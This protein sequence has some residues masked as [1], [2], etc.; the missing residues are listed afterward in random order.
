MNRRQHWI[1]AIKKFKKTKM[2]SFIVNKLII[3]TILVTIVFRCFVF[4][5]LSAHVLCRI[6]LLKILQPG[7]NGFEYLYVRVY[8]R[9]LFAV[10]KLLNILRKRTVFYYG[11]ND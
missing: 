7:R 3:K 11:K 1:N 6:I 9:T 10:L 5:F 4:F 8:A 2:F